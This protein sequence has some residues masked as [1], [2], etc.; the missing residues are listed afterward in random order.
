MGVVKSL[1]VLT[2]IF[3][4]A[5]AS[6]ADDREL[7]TLFGNRGVEGAI[8][9]SSLDGKKEY[10]WNEDRARKRFVPA[11]TFKIPHTLIALDQGAVS[12]EKAVIPWDGKKQEVRGCNNDQRLETAF[13]LSCVWFYQELAK[14]MDR[15]KYTELLGKT[16]YGN[17]LAGPDLTTFWLAG[18]LSISPYEQVLFLRNLYHGS[19]PYK[20]EHMEVVKKLMVNEVNPLF[21]VR[22]KTGW[23]ARTLPEQGWFVGYV[24]TGG[25]VWL[26]ATHIDIKKAA[27]LALRKQITLD[28][29]KLKG[30]IK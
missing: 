14:R 10:V 28:A 22:A 9:I 18:D 19:L 13:P 2:F 26:F 29:L 30:I 16:G 5:G 11:S 8:V 6:S 1:V 15:A 7:E 21:T 24:E 20:K 3:L 4:F 23:A 17:G 12:D 25:Q 27:D